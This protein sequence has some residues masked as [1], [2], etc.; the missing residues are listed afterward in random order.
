MRVMRIHEVI[1][2]I[3]RLGDWLILLADPDTLRGFHPL[4]AFHIDDLTHRCILPGEMPFV[5]SP[6]AFI[7]VKTR[8]Q[9]T[10]YSV[11]NVK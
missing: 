2:R 3:L 10:W 1:S 8:R 5:S 7:G 9:L 4:R 6:R 11:F